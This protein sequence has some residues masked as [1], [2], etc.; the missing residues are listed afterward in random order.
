MNVPRV[1]PS[2]GSRSRA[3][4]SQLSSTFPLEERLI[5]RKHLKQPDLFKESWVSRV[6]FKWLIK[7]LKNGM[8]DKEHMLNHCPF[9][10]RDTRWHLLVGV[11]SH[12]SPRAAL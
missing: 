6:L 7:H 4:K 3:V 11:L 10:G 1:G 12:L 9:G 2:R 5:T 8:W